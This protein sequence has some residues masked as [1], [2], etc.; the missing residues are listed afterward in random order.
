MAFKV[1]LELLH[2]HMDHGVE[3][4]KPGT[5]FSPDEPLPDPAM[6]TRPVA[7]EVPDPGPQE[8][9]APPPG[10]AKAHA[11]APA[12]AREAPAP[13]PEVKAEPQTR[14]AGRRPAHG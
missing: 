9:P 2:P 8:P 11:P 4:Y 14:P 10:P 7:V 12:P 6:V 1:M 5:L 3:V 13:E